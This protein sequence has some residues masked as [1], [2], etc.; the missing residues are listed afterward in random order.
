EAQAATLSGVFDV[1]PGGFQVNFNPLASTAGFT[2]LIV[3]YEPLITY[4][5]K[6]Q[7]PKRQE[8]ERQPSKAGRQ[9]Q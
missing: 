9:A 2:W 8:P 5:E 7:R 6:L 3:Y 4:D 1:G